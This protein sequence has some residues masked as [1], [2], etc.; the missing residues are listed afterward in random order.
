MSGASQYIREVL[1]HT[2]PPPPIEA[3]FFYSSQVPIDDPLSPV[4]PASSKIPAGLP[5]KPFSAYDNTSLDNAWHELRRKILKYNEEHGEKPAVREASRARAGSRGVREGKG[6][7]RDSGSKPAVIRTS[8]AKQAASSLN[9]VDG[10]ADVAVEPDVAGEEGSQSATDV[11]ALPGTTGTPFIRAPSGKRPSDIRHVD[12]VPMTRPKIHAHDT[13]VWEDSSHL[14]EHSPAPEQRRK[15]DRPE[16]SVP[17]GVSRLHKVEM[18]ELVMEPIY[19]TPIHDSAQMVRGTWFYQDTMMPVE[20]DVA[21]MLEAGYVELQV[22]TETWKDELASAV[23]VGAAGEEKIAHKLWPEVK[24]KAHDSRPTSRRGPHDPED[25][26]RTATLNLISEGETPEQQQ[27][28]AIE[29]AGHIIDISTG[30]GGA[31]NK[32]AGKLAY[33]RQGPPRIYADFGV[34]YANER[35]ARLLSTSLMPSAYYG[36]RPLASYIRKS[37]KLGIPVVRGFDEAMWEKLHPTKHTQKTEKAEHG[38]ATSGAGTPPNRRRKTDPNLAKAERPQVTDLILVI[39][40]IGQKLSQRMESFHFTHAMDAF[41]RDVNV[42]VGTEQVSRHFREGMG[43]I[44]VLPVN[45]RHTLTFEEGGYRDGPDELAGSNEFS[46]KDITPN[47][48]P[49][50]RNIVSDVMLDIPYYLSH[51]QP[52]MIAA[53]IREANR[54]YQLWCQ[55]NAGF[56]ENGRVHII[57]H[58]LGSVMSIDILSRQPTTLPKHL[59]D[60][61]KVD[62]ANAQLEHFLFPTSNLFLAGSPAGFFLLLK[63]AQLLP[64]I[65]HSS[66]AAEADPTSNQLTICGEQGQYGCIPVENVYNIINGYD[67]VSY[68]MN[69]AVDSTYAS[70]LKQAWIPTTTAGWFGGKSSTSWFGGTSTGSDS[71]KPPLL[72]RL[73]SNVEMETHDFTREEVAEKRMLL[74][75][76]NGQVDFFVRY[77]G[78]PLEIQYLTM[79]GAHSSYW[80]L[81]DF[82]RMIVAEVGRKPGRDGTLKGIR[83]VK[84]PL[85]RMKEG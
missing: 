59:R 48:L 20:A 62:L 54:V 43:G 46:L 21:N 55:H 79:L 36:R 4:P 10:H 29:A 17:V 14:V 11:P 13:Y 60:P 12:P 16:M 33:G 22:W 26:L 25:L 6:S 37:H 50:V 32:A 41:R 15:E 52:K 19:W 70:S 5:P 71:V 64:R 58:S 7:R 28:K 56:A 75:N 57:G 47:T 18:P 42:E 2:D 84:K 72:P 77:G 63:K 44:M 35:E 3:R 31:D 81:R 69:A 74:L 38:V 68:R 61:T 49:S 66:A 8:L 73:P 23:E 65:D 67:P 34:I 40:G 30:P 78:G 51:H 27:Q 82:T 85:A 53:V 76:D 9:Q 1:H 24:S 45:W 83:A 39:H 80:L